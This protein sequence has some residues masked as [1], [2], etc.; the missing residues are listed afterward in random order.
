MG[1]SVDGAVKNTQESQAKEGD[2]DRSTV[3]ETLTGAEVAVL[4]VRSGLQKRPFLG[5]TQPL[6]AARGGAARLLLPAA[7]LNCLHSR[8]YVAFSVL[9]IPRQSITWCAGVEVS[10]LQS[11]APLPAPGGSRGLR[12]FRR[13]LRRCRQSLLAALPWP[14]QLSGF[15]SASGTLAY[16]I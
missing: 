6:S 8:L 3:S 1:E 9:G 2:C 13:A 16:L 12:P 4:S 7:P 11:Q 14:F 5:G 15:D 10:R